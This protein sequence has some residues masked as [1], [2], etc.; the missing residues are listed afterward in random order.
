MKL[1]VSTPSTKNLKYAS[2]VPVMVFGPELVRFM[3]MIL[4]SHVRLV[5]VRQY[6]PEHGGSV[7]VVVVLVVV[8]VVLVVVVLV[9]VVV[10]TVV[11]VHMSGLSTVFP[12][13][14]T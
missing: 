12:S 3:V 11:V 13:G 5:M 14:H 7:V 4:L 10:G 6:E 1:L 9:V 8:V 2:I